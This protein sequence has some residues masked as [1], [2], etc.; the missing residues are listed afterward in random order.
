MSEESKIGIS[1]RI[2]LLGMMGVG[3]STIGKKLSSLLRYTFIDLDKEIEKQEGR[4]I[5]D[6]FEQSGEDYFRDIEAKTLRSIHKEHMVIA[7]GGG[8]PCFNNNIQYINEHGTSVYLR[9]NPGLIFQRIYRSA[10]KRPLLKGMYDEQL[11]EFI[12][13]KMDE[14]EPFYMQA[15][16]VFEI[17]LQSVESLVIAIS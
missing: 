14:R 5:S 1:S 8:T 11:R 15:H 7:T 16:H 13:Q 10:D 6:I 4:T 9:A 2:Y 12:K 17:P 3:K